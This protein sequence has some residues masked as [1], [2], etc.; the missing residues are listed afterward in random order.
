MKTSPMAVVFV[1]VALLSVGCER[2]ADHVVVVP[3]A[4][5]T[6][7]KEGTPVAIVTGPDSRKSTRG[8]EIKDPQVIYHEAYVDGK[9]APA[10]RVEVVPE[11]PNSESVWVEGHWV[12]ERN[13]HEDISGV[14]HGEQ[15]GWHPGYWK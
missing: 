4:P 13:A 6:V 2:K 10:M 15:W 8:V 7:V 9:P 3:L 12:R 11:R 14:S 1:M 5:G